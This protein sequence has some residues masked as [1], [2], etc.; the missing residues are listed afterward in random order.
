MPSRRILSNSKLAPI[1]RNALNPFASFNSDNV[2][3]LT[4][5]VSG[6]DDIVVKGLDVLNADETQIKLSENLVKTYNTQ[7]EFNANWRGKN[8]LYYEDTTIGKAIDLYLPNSKSYGLSY[9][10][11]DLNFQDFSYLFNRRGNSTREFEVSFKLY[12]GSPKSIF[13]SINDSTCIIDHPTCSDSTPN[14]YSF[15]ITRNLINDSTQEGIKFRI[16]AIFDVADQWNIPITNRPSE[17]ETGDFRTIIKISDISC[18]LKETKSRD[19]RRTL[20]NGSDIYSPSDI[21]Y[22]HSLKITPGIAIKDDVMLQIMGKTYA[23]KDTAI[24]LDLNDDLSWIKGQK[25]INADFTKGDDSQ[26]AYV[27]NGKY[28]SINEARKECFYD[29]TTSKIKVKLDDNHLVDLM[30]DF[31]Y[32]ENIDKKISLSSLEV[33]RDIDLN[34]L[35]ITLKYNGDKNITI[36]DYGGTNVIFT[37]V[38]ENGDKCT[39]GRY[40]INKEQLLTIE[41]NDVDLVS[42]ENRRNNIAVA[43]RIAS[44]GERVN[45]F[46]VTFDVTNLPAK[47]VNYIRNNNITSKS[48]NGQTQVNNIGNGKFEI[49]I[50]SG[51]I[52]VLSDPAL[53][54]RARTNWAYVVLYYAYF[55]NPKPNIS[56]IGLARE[57]EVKDPKFR[58]DYLILAK[59]RFIDPTTID[60]ISYDERQVQTLPSSNNINYGDNCKMPEIWDKVPV[61]VTDAIDALRQQLIDIKEKM[62]WDD[63]VYF[64]KDIT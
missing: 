19:T 42:T 45:P 18:C 34:V 33:K 1:Q 64:W 2:N 21:H 56:Y 16:S 52:K 28:N 24:Y 31:D 12:Y 4:R 62:N 59:V 20:C 3:L 53:C 9:V 13:V 48:W 10:E 51:P 43:N 58:E 37:Y 25:Y 8:C 60:I 36:G 23:E 22:V 17:F 32:N 49:Y 15:K 39:I 35:S 40:T 50:S 14:Q 57:E 44:S 29:E 38:D 7:E 41:E 55:K 54:T 27:L 30:D 5:T 11:C 26:Y 61:T 46:E 63:V 6:G 47:L